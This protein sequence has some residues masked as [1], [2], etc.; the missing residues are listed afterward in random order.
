VTLNLPASRSHRFEGK[1]QL[2]AHSFAHLRKLPASAVNAT[3]S[4]QVFLSFSLDCRAMKTRGL[5]TADSCVRLLMLFASSL[6]LPAFM[7]VSP[8][9]Q[10]GKV[11][12]RARA[13]KFPLRQAVS[14][15]SKDLSVN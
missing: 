9:K 13:F 3:S 15:D 10:S 14:E 4:M 5:K 12:A 1:A 8:S 11:D 2:L 7:F 6:F